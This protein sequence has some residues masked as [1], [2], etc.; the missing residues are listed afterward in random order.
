[1]RNYAVLFT[2][3]AALPLYV[4]CA[5]SDETTPAGG[6]GQNT[7][8]TAPTAGTLA[9]AGTPGAGSPTGGT[10]GNAGV[11]FAPLTAMGRKR[12]ALIR[13]S[14][15]RIAPNT[16]DTSPLNNAVIDGAAP[17]YGTCV[18]RTPAISRRIS[19]PRCVDVPLPPDP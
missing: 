8:G 9:V 7:G 6:A 11:G 16:H 13:G 15:G 1:M 5:A 3:A 10:P 17:L 18:M 14:V 19:P 12:P 4:A 2:L